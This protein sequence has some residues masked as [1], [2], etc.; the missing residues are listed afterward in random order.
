MTTY[1]ITEA[2]IEEL[3]KVLPD[4]DWG[5]SLEVTL[6]SLPMVD[7]EPPRG[8]PNLEDFAK[9]LCTE[10]GSLDI[11]ET[12]YRDQG[13]SYTPYSGQPAWSTY[14]L[15]AEYALNAY[16]KCAKLYT[17]PQAPTPI[18]SDDV[19]DEMLLVFLDALDTPM[20]Y[21]ATLAAAYNAF[22][23]NRNEAK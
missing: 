18:T 16:E 15:D 21:R 17:S 1:L 13:N 2:Q 11:Y 9:Q 19:T 14:V 4:N 7:S 6:Q 8:V 3:Y 23:K 10:H 20:N 22:I 12:V 5:K